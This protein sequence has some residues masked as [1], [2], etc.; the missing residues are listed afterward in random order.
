MSWHHYFCTGQTLISCL[1][2]QQYN[3]YC[4]FD[5]YT[6]SA[7]S[8]W[9]TTR[10]VPEKQGNAED[11]N[12]ET[13][14]CQWDAL[15]VYDNDSK[16][17]EGSGS[18]NIWLWNTSMCSFV[19]QV[20]TA[21]CHRGFGCRLEQCDQTENRSDRFRLGMLQTSQKTGRAWPRCVE[22]RT[23]VVRGS[24]DGGVGGVYVCDWKSPAKDSVGSNDTDGPYLVSQTV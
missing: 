19:V 18:L 22:V 11:G 8:T 9:Q 15:L 2:N 4:S 24:C 7:S 12:G 6:T 16:P 1:S 10:G 13:E 21:T 23:E 14:A 5:L 3:A 17:K 20:I